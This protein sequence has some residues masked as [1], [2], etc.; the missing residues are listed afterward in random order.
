MSVLSSSWNKACFQ[1]QTNYSNT[2]NTFGTYRPFLRVKRLVRFNDTAAQRGIVV[3]D[4]DDTLRKV[5]H[6]DHNGPLKRS[7]LLNFIWIQR[8]SCAAVSQTPVMNKLRLYINLL[9]VIQI[10]FLNRRLEVMR[11]VSLFVLWCFEVD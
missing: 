1:L 7:S 3:T 8:S 4:N 10:G 5:S 6:S 11:L 2:R 9:I